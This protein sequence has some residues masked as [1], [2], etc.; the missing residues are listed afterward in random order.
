MKNDH[1][2][3][4]LPSTVQDSADALLSRPDLVPSLVAQVYQEAPAAERGRLLEHLL[5]PLS[6]LSLAAVANGIFAKIT[7]SNGWATLR[8]KPEDA[9]RVDA[10]DVM[11][12]VQHV[13]QVS[14]QAIEGLSKVIG[15][16]PVLTGSAAAAMLLALLAKQANSRTPVV[17][18]DFDLIA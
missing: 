18:N 14:V 13:Q 12:L 6:L 8:V 16:S 1:L 17:G 9:S 11:A 3:A 4:K 10:G 7:W 5:T 15:A 2:H